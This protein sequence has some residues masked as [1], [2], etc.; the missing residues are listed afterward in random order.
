MGSLDGVGEAVL[1]GLHRIV[2]CTDVWYVNVF[3]SVVVALC[4]NIVSL[5]AQD[6]LPAARTSVYQLKVICLAV[7]GEWLRLNCRFCAQHCV[8][9][10]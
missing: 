9:T 6:H 3:C 1:V 4:V 8:A 5:I 10:I 2:K 7:R